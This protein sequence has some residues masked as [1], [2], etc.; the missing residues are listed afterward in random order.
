VTVYTGKVEVGQ[1]I[2]T[3]LSQVVAEELR[4]PLSAIELVMA[5]TERTPFD[6]GTAG[7]RTTPD[8]AP[9]LRR[10]A[11]A[12]RELLLDLAAR[13]ARVE[14]GWL[15]VA[16][17][18]VTHPP[19]K[20]SFSFGQ[21]T[22]GQKLTRTVGADVPVTPAAEWKVAGTAAP[23]VEGRAL[24]TGKHKFASDVKR[25]GMLF[26]KVLRPATLNA[27][28]VSVHLKE[29]EALPGVTAVRD[30]EFVGVAAPSE[31]Q[32]EK[33]LAAI[34][35]EWKSVPQPS[36]KELFEYLKKN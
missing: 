3:S 29:A 23:K 25:P 12:A 11:A 6:G 22:K 10:V 5:D 26:G 30:G 16:D 28:L 21:L 35:A 31:H 36:S 20:R 8:M 33:A 13:Q 9:Q 7:S 4:L 32:A 17:G 19:P 14:R 1:N 2:R 24:V 27:S 15:V 18:K 34:K